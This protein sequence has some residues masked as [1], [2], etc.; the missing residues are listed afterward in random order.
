MFRCSLICRLYFYPPSL[1]APG[2]SAFARVP[3]GRPPREHLP[4]R[5]AAPIKGLS[6]GDGARCPP[7]P[8]PTPPPP[9]LASCLPFLRL[10]PNDASP[11]LP[12]SPPPVELVE[13]RGRRRG[14]ERPSVARGPALVPEERL[15]GAPFR[16]W[17]FA[18]GDHRL[19][20]RPRR[21]RSGAFVS[22]SG[23][24]FLISGRQLLLIDGAGGSGSKK[25]P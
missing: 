14:S 13:L 16:R 18:N 4:V 2:L 5:P 25:S 15:T 7:P 10:A 20:R 17:P 21:T 11:H 3:Y 24:S 22:L 23:R 1:P 9:R 8:P 6:A 19:N 12:I